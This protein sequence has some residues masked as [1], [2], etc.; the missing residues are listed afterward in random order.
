M[1]SFTHKSDQLSVS[2]IIRCLNEQDHI[3]NLLQAIKEQ[4]N[5]PEEIIVV[6]SGSTDQ[7]LDIIRAFGVVAAHISPNDFT[8]GRSLNRGCAIA[9]G[10]ILVIASAHVLPVDKFWLSEL[11]APFIHP[12][13]AL[14]YGRQIGNHLTTFSEHQVFAQQFPE[15]SNFIQKTPFCN[16]ANAAIRRSV[17]LSR[18]YDEA[19]TGLEDLDMG[20]WVLQNGY[21]LAYNANAAVI[22]IHDETP[23]KI[24]N[25][26]KREAIALKRILPD[27]HLTFPEFIWLWLSNIV[28]DLLRALK[29][30]KFVSSVRE[31]VVFRTMQY[32]GMYRGIHDRSV[33]THEMIMRFYYPR[34]PARFKRMK[35][36]G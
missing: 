11:L 31:I 19:L 3:G 4:T 2:V 29:Q 25:R 27:S 14:V 7:T 15:E 12:R 36:N 1:P 18:P 34:M 16:N 33:M 8:F 26:Y 20:N 28:M 9:K 10:D 24:F 21:H 5:R 23:A 30:I 32:F 17:W 6:D 13:T 22:H 35:K